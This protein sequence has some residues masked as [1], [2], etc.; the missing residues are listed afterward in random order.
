MFGSGGKKAFALGAGAGFIG[1]AVAAA[2]AM[3][4]YHRYRQY[5]TMMYYGGYGM[6]HGWN[7]RESFTFKG[8]E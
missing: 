1:G 7:D 5:Q 3:S 6:G 2:G 4:I 8:I